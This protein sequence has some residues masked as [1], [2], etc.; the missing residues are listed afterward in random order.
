MGMFAER[1]KKEIV[2]YDRNSVTVD[3]GGQETT[4]YA[5]PLT[6]ADLDQLMKRHPK[7]AEAPTLGATVDLLIAKCEDLDGNKAFDMGDKPEL[8]RVELSKINRIRAALFPDQDV[9]L[10]DESVDA[11]V[12][13]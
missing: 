5:K 4:L 10:T 11:E 1:L 6:G 7:F 2:S 9:D 12:G 8:L 3:F 13:N